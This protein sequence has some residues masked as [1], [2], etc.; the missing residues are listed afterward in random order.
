M[1]IVTASYFCWI[2]LLHNCGTRKNACPLVT[3]LDAVLYLLWSMSESSLL[4]SQI[5]ARQLF[6]LVRKV[7]RAPS[8][9]IL[10]CCPI[11][12][13]G[14]GVD[15]SLRP[16]RVAKFGYLLWIIFFMQRLICGQLFYDKSNY[17]GFQVFRCFGRQNILS[18][19]HSN[20]IW[21]PDQKSPVFDQP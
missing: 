8:S 14:S 18:I 16:E 13:L 6:L 20:G 1:S 9:W 5:F 19:R 2:F 21:I 7:S 4:G 3:D 17:R 15:P 12:A 10:V 11:F